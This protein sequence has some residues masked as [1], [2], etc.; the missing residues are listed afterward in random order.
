[1]KAQVSRGSKPQFAGWGSELAKKRHIVVQTHKSVG[2]K[3]DFYPVLVWMVIPLSQED[4][5]HNIFRQF[6]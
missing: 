1:M 3:S 2:N 4:H 6:E 5:Q